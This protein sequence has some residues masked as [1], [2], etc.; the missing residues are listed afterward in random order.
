MV[1]VDSNSRRDGTRADYAQYI[2]IGFTL[3]SILV[4]PGIVGF[5]LDG[6]LNT[7]PLLLLVGLGIGFIGEMYYIYRIL[8]RTGDE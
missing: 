3:F 5:F 2:G 8:Q 4:V 7:L 6:L 1:M